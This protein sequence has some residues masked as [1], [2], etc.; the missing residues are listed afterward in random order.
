MARANGEEGSLAGNLLALLESGVGADVTLVAGESELPAHS[1]ILAAR[2]PVFAA[3]LRHDT[4]EAHTGRVEVPGVREAVLRQLVRFVYTD[5]APQ[6]QSM[7]AE[8]LPAADK[9]DLPLLKRRCEQAL[10]RSLTVENAAAAAVLAELHSCPLLKSAAVDFVASHPQVMATEGWKNALLHDVEV[11]A[12]ICSLV[13]AAS[14]KTRSVSEDDDD[15]LAEELI[16][17]AE[18]GEHNEVRKL[19]AE[20]APLDAKDGSGD[21]ALHCAALEGH[22]E[23]VRCL[24]YAGANVNTRNSGRQTPLHYAAFR[25][26]VEVMWVLLGASARADAQ[27]DKQQTPLHLA[28]AAARL[29]AVKVLLAAGASKFK[30]DLNDND[31]KQLANSSIRDIFDVL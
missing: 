21:S 7:A 10:A 23:V 27:D 28:V 14:S 30:K 13:A 2:S 25:G 3:M 12:E 18:D 29:G 5:T 22:A 24:V 15:K 20:G 31:P 19:I 4:R 26:H 9:Y 1:T 16:E 17:A 8:L 6:L 11:A